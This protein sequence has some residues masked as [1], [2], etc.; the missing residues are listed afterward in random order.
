MGRIIKRGEVVVVKAVKRGIVDPRPRRQIEPGCN[1]CDQMLAEG[2]T[3]FPPHEAR[4]DCESGKRPHCTCSEC[5][6]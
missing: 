5:W 2:Q 3:F 4:P 6:D 1:F